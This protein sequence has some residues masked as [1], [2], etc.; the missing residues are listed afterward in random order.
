MA[1]SAKIS[2]DRATALVDTYWKKNWSVLCIAEDCIVKI[3][4]GQKWLFN[5]VSK[6]WYSLRYDKDKFS[7]LNQGTGVFCFDTWVK[8]IRSKRPQLT[9]QFHDETIM[10]IKLGYRKQAEKLIRDAMEA[11][12]NELNLNI[13]LDCDVQFG[14]NYAEIH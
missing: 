9:G 10:C 7:T 1:R 11:T 6:L 12:N 2:V 3:V 5:P 13:K 4:N 8:H 14:L